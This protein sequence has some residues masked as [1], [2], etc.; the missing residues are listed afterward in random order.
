MMLQRSPRHLASVGAT[1]EPVGKGDL[2]LAEL[3]YSRAGRTRLHKRGKHRP[4]RR[5]HLQMRIEDKLLVVGI[6]Q[7][8]GHR[9]S[10]CSPGCFGENGS[11]QRS[12]DH[13]EL[14]RGR[15]AFE[16]KQETVIER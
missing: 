6:A 8:N 11:V 9:E 1:A 15:G 4:N 2:L 16:P 5:L 3:A 14:R 12:S 7:A 13:V 10:Q